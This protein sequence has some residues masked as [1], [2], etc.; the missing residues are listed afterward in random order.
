MDVDLYARLSLAK[1]GSTLGV[2]RQVEE[3]MAELIQPRGWTLRH[4]FVDNN[5]SATTGVARPGFEA[6]LGASPRVP[7]VV[8]HTDRL[9]RVNRDLE[10]VI[11]LDV[12]VYALRSGHLDL[13]TPA[14]RAV[15]RTITAWSQ[16]EGEQK[17]ER[18]RA[19]HRQRVASGRP[20]WPSRPFGYQMDLSIQPEEAQALREAYRAILRGSSLRSVARTLN[21]AGLLTNKGN[22]WRA[23]TLGPVLL[24]PRNAGLVAY[25]GEVTG[26]AEWPAIVPQ[27]TWLA[28]CRILNDPG[29]RDGAGR[30]PAYLLTGFAT[31]GKCGSYVKAGSRKGYTVYVCRAKSCVSIRTE[32]ADDATT[33]EILMGIGEG[34]ASYPLGEI[35]DTT[36]LALEAETLRHKLDEMAEDYAASILSR[37]QLHAGTEKVKARLAEIEAEMAEAAIHED[38]SLLWRMVA[39]LQQMDVEQQRA[40]VRRL[41]ASVVLDSPGRGQRPTRE[42]VR[43]TLVS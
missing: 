37:S 9:I 32:V 27:D 3:C 41:V 21:E 24:N 33:R 34:R 19:A 42:H 11:A 8:W 22:R 5:L 15:A 1:D 17:A 31:C 25:N 23:E 7:I 28:V 4:T 30:S 20:W 10:R 39:D 43:V 13:S 18:Q 35:A 16:Y 12:D 40:M 6:L 2:D 26:K 14:G 38:D 36:D 29:R